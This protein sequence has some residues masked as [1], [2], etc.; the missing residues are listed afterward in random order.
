MSFDRKT[1]IRRGIVNVESEMLLHVI[2]QLD[3]IYCVNF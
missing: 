1:I 3:L 2:V